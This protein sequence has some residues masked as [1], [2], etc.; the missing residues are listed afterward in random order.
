MSDEAVF[1]RFSRAAPFAVMTRMV[2]G[3]F[4]EEHADELFHS[5]RA[6]QYEQEVTFSAVA[7]AV[8]DVVAQHCEN[9]NQAYK[10]HQQKLRVSLQ[11]FYSKINSTETAISEALVAASATK[12]AGLQEQLNFTPWEI[13]PGYRCFGID[14]NVLAKTDKRLGVL[15]GTTGAPLPGK[16][17]ARFDLQ[18]RLFDRA[19]LL[20][21]AH[22]QESSTCDRIVADLKAQDVVIAD[23][24]YCV[25][26]FLKAIIAAGANFVIRQ[27][28]RLK[29]VLM[30]RRKRVG[31]TSTGMVYE[32]HM[33]LEKAEDFPVVRRVTIELDRPTRDGAM[34]IH[35]L[36][37]LP[38]AV[39]ATAIADVYR[40]RW[41]EENAFHVLQMTLTCELATVGNPRAALLLFSLAMLAYN[42]RQ[43]LFAALFAEHDEQEVLEVSH[44]HVSKEISGS[45]EGMLIAIEPSSWDKLIPKD[46]RALAKLLRELVRP[47]KLSDYRK[48]KRGPKKKKPIRS[49]NVASSHISTSKALKLKAARD[50]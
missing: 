3:A 26:G 41:D 9:F 49:R 1:Q 33:R 28:G 24:H 25:V 46:D 7:L 22:A 40:R 12:A 50:P 8:A 10:Q 6:L 42:L 23:R 14:G 31:R 16:V 17:V 15:R 35:L 32:Q 34:E 47:I 43:V 45:T 30:G 5:H 20:E 38:E 21:D 4:L 19:Y 39:E 44:F 18:L 13:L 48:A 29:G 11:S 2:A 27:H 36:T 37:R